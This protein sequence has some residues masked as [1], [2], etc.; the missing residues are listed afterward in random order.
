MLLLAFFGLAATGA[1]TLLFPW[2]ITGAFAAEGWPC[3][4]VELIVVLP[5]SVVFYLV[6]RRGALFADAGLGAML[7]G[8][9]AALALLVAQ[10]QC[11][12]QQAPHLLVWHGTTAAIVIGSGALAGRWLRNRWLS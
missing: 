7:S 2:K 5:V 3:A 9:A 6:A 12:F 10:F 1:V 4:A 11:M 8:L